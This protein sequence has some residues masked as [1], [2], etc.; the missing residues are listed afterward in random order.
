MKVPFLEQKFEASNDSEIKG[1]SHKYTIF[2]KSYFNEITFFLQGK[3]YIVHIFQ[4]YTQMNSVKNILAYCFQCFIYPTPAFD[5]YI[6][7][8][9]NVILKHQLNIH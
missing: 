8:C 9:K 1:R 7:Q 6:T 4:V 2:V 3:K 5:I